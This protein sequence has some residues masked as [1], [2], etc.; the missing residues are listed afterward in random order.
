M[1]CRRNAVTRSRDSPSSVG[2]SRATCS[3]SRLKLTA[4]ALDFQVVEDLTDDAAQQPLQAG[5][6]DRREGTN[7]L[8]LVALEKCVAAFLDLERRQRTEHS[9]ARL[10]GAGQTTPGRRQ[11]SGMFVMRPA[12]LEADG[13]RQGGA[14]AADVAG[15]AGEIL[16]IVAN[17]VGD[18]DRF[19]VLR[20]RGPHLLVCPGVERP[21]GER[22]LES[23]R[24][25]LAENVKDLEGR[26]RFWMACPPQLRALAH[27]QR[28]V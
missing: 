16:E 14:A 28:Q 19:A 1:E 3:I 2:A 25:L 13:E 26:Q 12:A 9:L 11:D 4:P 10:F 6:L 27:R 7:R 17:L 22:H 20:Q 5:V 8:F 15:A 21:D 24:S 23:R 18:S